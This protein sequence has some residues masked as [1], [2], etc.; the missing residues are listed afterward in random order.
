VQT[1]SPDATPI[2]AAVRHDFAA[3]AAVELPNREALGYPPFASMVRIVVRGRTKTVA[4]S[5]ADAIGRSL[6][7]RAETT[8]AAVRVLGPAPAP[9]VKLR[10]NFRYQLQLQSPNSDALRDVVRGAMAALR[11]PQG[12]AW[13]VDI[14]PLDMM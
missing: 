9:M 11:V 10:G 4:Q 7:E 1:F 5:L 3:F 13:I 8:S 6:H 14:D 12:A 2:Q